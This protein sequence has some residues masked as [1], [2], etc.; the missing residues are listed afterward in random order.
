MLN[1]VKLRFFH[2]IRGKCISGRKLEPFGEVFPGPPGNF[3]CGHF[4][5]KITNKKVIATF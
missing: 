4:F 1:V 3:L 2:L 5:P